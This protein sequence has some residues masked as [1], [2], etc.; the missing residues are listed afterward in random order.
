MKEELKHL[1]TLLGLVD[2]NLERNDWC[3][4]EG[5]HEI[6]FSEIAG[7]L[8]EAQEE[9]KKDNIIHFEDELG[10][11]LW[12]YLMLVKLS[13]RDGYIKSATS[14]FEHVHQKFSERLQNLEEDKKDDKR[15]LWSEVK[16]RQKVRLAE[17]HQALYGEKE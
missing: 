7:E 9:F 14:L 10:D 15:Y 6:Y 4:T 13:E 16:E 5:I 2:Y 1:E 11:I 17:E 12:C 8:E 3:Q